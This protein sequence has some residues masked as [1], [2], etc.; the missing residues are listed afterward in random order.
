MNLPKI[1]IILPVYKSRDYLDKIFDCLQNQSLREIEIIFVND[2]SPDDSEEIIFQK[3]KSDARII[4]INQKNSGPASAVQKGTECA[5]GE[6]LMFL[7]ADDWIDK[8]TCEVAYNAALNEDADMVFWTFKKEYP[9]KTI[10]AYLVFNKDMQFDSNNIKWL[11]RRLFG[12]I[13]VEVAKPF[14]NDAISSVWGKLYRRSIITKNNIQFVS[15]NEIGSTDVL[16]NAQVIKYVQRATYLHR[17]FNHYRQDNPSSLTKNYQ[18]TLF[19]KYL[20]LFELMQN[21]LDTYEG[22]ERNEMEQALSNRIS[23]SLINIGLSITSQKIKE[24][25]G[26]R[27]K[28]Y[29]EVLNHEVYKNALR[30][31]QMEYLPFH[32]KVYFY[33]C[34]RKWAIPAYIMTN[35]INKFR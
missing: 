8:N 10:D 12:L 29:K 25:H 23:C 17:F 11:R 4:L 18:F 19:N 27:M 21:E 22:D 7:D 15:T 34:K 14:M 1:S 35:I 16:Y 30:S 24:S 26:T 32:W 3:S 33:L 28:H 31:F 2:G 6:Y 5:K 20:K 13:G 9:N